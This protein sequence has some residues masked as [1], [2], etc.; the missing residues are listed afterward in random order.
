MAATVAT[1]QY[2]IGHI[3]AIV[4]VD[5]LLLLVMVAGLAQLIESIETVIV[6]VVVSS[7]TMSGHACGQV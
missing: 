1:R 5:M 3:E 7:G 2:C 6:A 4:E